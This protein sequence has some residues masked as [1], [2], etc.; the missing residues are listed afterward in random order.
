MLFGIHDHGIYLAGCYETG[1]VAGHCLFVS[2][3][4]KG[5]VRPTLTSSQIKGVTLFLF[6]DDVPGQTPI[7]APESC[8]IIL[9]LC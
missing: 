3:L 7:S 8:F 6:M 4:F 9:N 1:P 2:F 5:T